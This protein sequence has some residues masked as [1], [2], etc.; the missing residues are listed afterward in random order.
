MNESAYY[1]DLLIFKGVYYGRNQH[2][3]GKAIVKSTIDVQI[4]AQNYR[5]TR[6]IV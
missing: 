6:Y 3:C 4:K 1:E 2:G 5:I